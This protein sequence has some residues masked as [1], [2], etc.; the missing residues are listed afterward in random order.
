MNLNINMV[1]SPSVN[2][3][4]EVPQIEPK[5][6]NPPL[7]SK[8]IEIAISDA[9]EAGFFLAGGSLTITIKAAQ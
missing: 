7:T 3:V 9:I 4:G 2:Y 6:L 1:F 8:I 5:N